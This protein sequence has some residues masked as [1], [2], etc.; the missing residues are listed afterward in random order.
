VPN[1]LQRWRSDYI[2]WVELFALANL[3]FL[4]FDIFLAHSTNGF[5]RRAEY[6]PLFFSL[7]SPVLLAVALLAREY[8]NRPRVWRIVGFI[9]GFLS[10]AIGLAGVIYHLD[11]QFFYER[12]IRS[13]TYA[14]PF[15]APLAYTG[16]GMLL[17]LNRFEPAPTG[18]WARWVLF[19]ALGGFLGNFALSLTDHAENAFF[20][21]T[22]WLPVASSAF[23]VSFLAVLLFVPVSAR[24]WKA[25]TV[26][27]LLQ[28]V[29][30]VTGFLLHFFADL[31]GPSRSLFQNVINGA[32]P[33][34]PLLLPNLMLLALIGLWV[35][36]GSPSPQPP[37][38]PTSG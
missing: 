11:S 35:L 7:A 25:C 37:P 38:P 31:H 23:A 6:Y 29:V 32:P 14:A 12:T 4:A 26:V 3:A 2:L 13:L 19:L 16:V 10:V 5:L 1:R 36:H 27:I 33:F 20:H 34:A 30:G 15:A 9:V 8:W 21:W 22:E 28:A 24:Y 17:L 18:E